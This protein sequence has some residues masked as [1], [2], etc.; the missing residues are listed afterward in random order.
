MQARL[1]FLDYLKSE[2]FPKLISLGFAGT[3][4]TYRR[5][6]GEVISMVQF[7]EHRAGDRCCINLGL[8]LKFLPASWARHSLS[9]EKLTAADCEFQWR[10]N[11]PHKHDYWWRY[12]RWFH[13]PVRCAAH[14]LKTYL[15]YGET[16]FEHYRS[17]D[18]FAGLFTPEDFQSGAWRSASHGIRPQRGALTMARIYLHL[19]RHDQARAFAQAGIG[20]ISPTTALAADYHDIL[21][22]A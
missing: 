21:K 22:A 7:Q 15:D 17:V 19:G 3:E 11:P 2:F 12:H 9:I 13:S 14:M 16:V 20:Q 1:L 4:N 18:D 5:V 6:H 10:L 8:H